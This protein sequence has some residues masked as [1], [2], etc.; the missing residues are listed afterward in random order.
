MIQQFGAAFLYFYVLNDYG[1]R[2]SALF[3]LDPEYGY[4]PNPTDVYDPS[5][6]GNGN[7]NYENLKFYRKLEW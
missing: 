1:I 2:P 7:T 4:L 3:Y 6:N 5:K